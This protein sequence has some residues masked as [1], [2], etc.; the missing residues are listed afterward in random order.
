MEY[1]EKGKFSQVE[2]GAYFIWDNWLHK[3]L[4]DYNSIGRGYTCP[5]KMLPGTEVVILDNALSDSLCCIGVRNRIFAE[6]TPSGI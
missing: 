6:F 3:K 4:D 2:T 1:M 5:N